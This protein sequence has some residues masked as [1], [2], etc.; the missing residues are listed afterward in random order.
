[1]GSLTLPPG[2]TVYVETPALIYTVERHPVYGP[3]LDPFWQAA[4]EGQVTPVSSDLIITEAL[5]MPL[6]RGDVE[7]QANYE[8][9]FFQSDMNLL[10]LD[11]D[12]LRDAA[13]LRAAIAGLRTPDALHAATALLAGCT[14]FLTNDAGFRRIPGLP[15]AVLDDVLAA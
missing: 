8:A 9:V 5:V 2:G 7:L 14:L 10:P 1:M 11:P 4:S 12:V 6:R 3:L 15:L 13:R